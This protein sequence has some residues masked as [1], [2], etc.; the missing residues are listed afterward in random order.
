[1]ARVVL[2][3][4]SKVFA[5]TGGTLVHGLQGVN[6]VLEQGE[7]L[8]LLGP[9][10]CGKSTTLRLTAGLERVTKG[11][12][13]I[14]GVVVNDMPPEKRDVAMMFQSHA[15]YPHL[16]IYDN[17][18]L[19][20]KLRRFS[21]SQI[22][23]RVM[24]TVEMLDIRSCLWRLPKELSGGEQQRVALGRALVRQAGILLLDEPLSN[25]DMPLR[26]QLRT[27][28]AQLHARLC[29]TTLYV[30]HDQEEAMT[31]GHRI[32]VMRK[33]EVQQIGAPME[34]YRHP[35]NLFVAGFIGSPP[36]NFFR[37]T[38]RRKGY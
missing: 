22:H 37:G 32:V 19:G 16:T 29:A 38:V 30:T 28:I 12:I 2:E 7:L 20:L 35:A 31:L 34:V 5:A 36:M 21:K 17:F 23:E 26:V 25:L 14:N 11:I 1:M 13:S 8:V 9:S 10:G 24:K 15:L 27:E 33:G 4:V 3:E 18:A 6:L